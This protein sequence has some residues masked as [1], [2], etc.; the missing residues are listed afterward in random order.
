MIPRRVL[1]WLLIGVCAA[2]G[3]AAIIYAILHG[4]LPS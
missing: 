3:L 1:V 4:P 2:L